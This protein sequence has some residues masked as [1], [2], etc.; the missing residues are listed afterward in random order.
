M[1]EIKIKFEEEKIRGKS[2]R[3]IGELSFYQIKNLFN[4]Q[5]ANDSSVWTYNFSVD[6]LMF[7]MNIQNFPNAYN[8]K[9]TVKMR[10]ICRVNCYGILPPMLY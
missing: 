5:G 3:K 10:F 4:A 2:Y 6:F 7:P 8:I 9:T 1:V